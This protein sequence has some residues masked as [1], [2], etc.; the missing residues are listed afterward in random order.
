MIL[1]LAS[2]KGELNVDDDDDDVINLVLRNPPF[3]PLAFGLAMTTKIKKVPFDN[4]LLSKVPN[5]LLLPVFFALPLFHLPW[6]ANVNSANATRNGR[7]A[8]FL[9]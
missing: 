1:H 7:Q 3:S 2:Q 4:P 5:Y 9:R 8:P 6:T